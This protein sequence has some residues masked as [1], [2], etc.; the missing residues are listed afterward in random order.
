[1]HFCFSTALR[2]CSSRFPWGSSVIGTRIPVSENTSYFGNNRSLASF[3]KPA[4]YDH[5]KIGTP[6]AMPTLT[7]ELDT[8]ITEVARYAGSS[9]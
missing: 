1:V 3:I 4:I 5:K 9:D 7:G 8:G 2:P 6:P